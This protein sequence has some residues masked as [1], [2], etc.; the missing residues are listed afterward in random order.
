VPRAA[1]AVGADG[2]VHLDDG[3]TIAAEHVVLTH[4]ARHPSMPPWAT[5]TAAVHADEVDLSTIE[6]GT[7]VVIVG[8]GIT[9]AHLAVAAR[10]RGAVV[11]I[12][13]RRRI[14]E[15]EFD[16][17]PGWLG[18][19]CMQEF[20]AI[21][22]DHRR[23]AVVHEAR[24]GGSVPVW[25][26]RELDVLAAN[27]KGFEVRVDDV[28]GWDGKRLSLASGRSTDADAVW[29]AT[30]WRADIANDVLVR[31]LLD[32][33]GQAGIAGFAPL[34]H[35]LRIRSTSVHVTGPPASL[36]LGPSAG[37]LSGARRSA[38]AIAAAVFGLE[39]ADSLG[40][41]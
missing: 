6:T 11:Q 5:G 4:G 27:P 12:V 2:C 10:A 13:C 18:P 41:N 17:D 20:R 15:R 14:V 29:C 40:A 39:R 26:L 35:H 38:R 3:T 32:R 7:R 16:S 21:D 28:V 1:R 19:K 33:T 9:A 36:V 30:G 34:D 8:G 22:D 31:P 25:L 37:N 23:A 24:G